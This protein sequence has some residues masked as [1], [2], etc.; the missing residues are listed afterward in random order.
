[1]YFSNPTERKVADI[2]ANKANLRHTIGGLQVR[3]QSV[4]IADSQTSLFNIYNA[5]VRA[6]PQAREGVLDYFTLVSKLNQ[7]RS[8]MRVR[9]CT[10]ASAYT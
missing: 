8:G 2:D 9:L 4:C 1:M 7:K 5:I 10:A 3:H 6:S